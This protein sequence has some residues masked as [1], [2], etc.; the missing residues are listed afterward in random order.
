LNFNCVKKL[1]YLLSIIKSFQKDGGEKPRFHSLHLPKAEAGKKILTEDGFFFDY[2]F[3]FSRILIGK[4][5]F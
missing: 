5:I 1:K 2:F 3:L 4:V